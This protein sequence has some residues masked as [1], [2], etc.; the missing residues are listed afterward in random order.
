MK[1]LILVDDKDAREVISFIVAE[2]GYE[3]YF[4]DG[5]IALSLIAGMAPDLMILDDWINRYRGNFCTALKDHPATKHIPLLLLSARLKLPQ[6]A[7]DCPADARLDKPFDIC[8][9]ED[10]ICSLV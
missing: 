10:M 2:K 8:D 9:L 1:I 5:D 7:T 3:V 4:G 6:T